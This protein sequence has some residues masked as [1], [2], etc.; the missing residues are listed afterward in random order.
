MRITFTEVM[1]NGDR[2]KA[3]L[4][5]DELKLF[6]GALDEEELISEARGS[7][8]LS[9]F[10]RTKVSEKVID[11]LP[12]LKMINTRSVGFDHI[13]AKHALE[14]GIAVTHVPDY[15]PYA[16]AEHAFC[17]LLAC[18]RHL[19]DAA[20]SVKEGA[21]DFM[22]FQGIELRGKTLGVIGT[23]KI[24]AEVIRIADGFGMK[25]VAFDVYKNE[26][27]ARQYE[28]PYMSLDEVLQGSDFI[29]VHVPLTPSTEGLIDR[30]ALGKMRE[31]SILIN[32]SRG[33]V[34][35]EAALR[36]ALDCGHL[37]AAGLD[38]IADETH[39]ENDPLRSSERA[40]IT[41]HIGF[42][43]RESIDRMMAEA[44]R[45]VNSF[46]SGS[47]VNGIPKEYLEKVKVAEHLRS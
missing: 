36:E 9:V 13:A 24:G 5:D 45:T 39:P 7:S 40:I 27:L 46:R 14:R 43:T 26:D 37:A 21:F 8:I 34:V 35:D 10:I 41:P 3:A 2:L 42:F 31:G 12:G 4:P 22:P 32:T 28:F 18:A 33:K 11:S 44:V 16:V 23:G 47:V 29:T 30:H 19:V 17:L 38:V 25:V 15:G 6:D 20:R 1:G